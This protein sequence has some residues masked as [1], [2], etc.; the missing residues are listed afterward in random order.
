MMRNFEII[1]NKKSSLNVQTIYLERGDYIKKK[2]AETLLVAK[3]SADV[4]DAGRSNFNNSIPNSSK[5][6]NIWQSLTYRRCDDENRLYLS[7]ALTKIE[8]SVK[9]NTA[10]KKSART[11]LLPVSF[12]N[13]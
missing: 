2:S 11:Y 9:G 5:N 10:P 1:S 7:V 3:P 6:V 13:I 12:T 4:Q 8:T